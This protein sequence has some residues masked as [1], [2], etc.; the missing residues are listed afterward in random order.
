MRFENNLYHSS[1]PQRLCPWG[2]FRTW[3]E[4]TFA[5]PSATWPTRRSTR[6][7]T[8]HCDRPRSANAGVAAAAAASTPTCLWTTSWFLSPLTA[9]RT[10]ASRRRP[11]RRS[12]RKTL[13]PSNPR[14]RGSTI[15][16]TKSWVCRCPSL[17]RR[18]CCTTARNNTPACRSI[19]QRWCFPLSFS[20][21]CFIVFL[22][23]VA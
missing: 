8:M 7:A 19:H 6:P 14:S 21:Y 5:G 16:E 17:W 22:D 3:R 2:V 12:R 13:S 4:S 1:I 9:R 18:T 11:K 20:D 15:W 23:N 10:N